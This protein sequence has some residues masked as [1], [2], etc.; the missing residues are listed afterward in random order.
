MQTDPS[1]AATALAQVVQVQAEYGRVRE[2]RREAILEAVH[3][4]VPLREVATAAQCSH[5]SVRRMVAADGAATIRLG[6]TEYSLTRQT[7]E[8]LIYKLSGYAAGA[9]PRDVELLGVGSGW[10]PDAG[11]LAA[12]LRAS[13]R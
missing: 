11:L 9:F 8:L 12:A 7:V 4:A 3:A 10:L 6:G 5:E 1:T 13:R 2:E